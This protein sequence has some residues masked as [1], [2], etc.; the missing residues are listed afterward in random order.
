[1]PIVGCGMVMIRQATA[2]DLPQILA[3]DQEIFGGYGG[4]ESPVVIAARLEVFPPGCVVLVET[5]TQ[6][7]AS[8][9]LGYL[10][11]EKWCTLRDPVLDEDPWLTHQPTGT[12]L[13]ITTLAVAPTHRRRGLGVQLVDYAITLA[14]REGCTAI[15][16]ET[17][18]AARFYARHGFVKIG[19]RRQRDILL[20]IMYYALP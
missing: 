1:M 12:I 19:E 15:V 17:A 13:N 2:V 20:H 7:E 10:T 16:L 8:L 4:D 18:W 5:L 11:T 3:L 14:R 9:L 6:G